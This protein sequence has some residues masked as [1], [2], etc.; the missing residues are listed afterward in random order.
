MN[1][2]ITENFVREHFKA[3]PLFSTIKVEEQKSYSK[4]INELLQS[5]AKV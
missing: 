5:R 2:R 3:D 4:R 1:E